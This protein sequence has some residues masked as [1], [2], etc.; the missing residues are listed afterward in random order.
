MDFSRERQKTG[1][2]I[3]THCLELL[4][5]Y[6]NWSLTNWPL[7][8]P[9]IYDSELP[10]MEPRSPAQVIDQAEG[11]FVVDRARFNHL[12]DICRETMI[13]HRLSL[14][15]DPQK[16]GEKWLLKRINKVARK[17]IFDFCEGWLGLS[18]DSNAP[19]STRWYVGIALFNGITRINDGMAENQGYHI[20]EN[21]AL[22]KPPGHWPTK[23]APGPHQ[24]DW[25]PNNK[26]SITIHRNSGGID[27]IHW[28]FDVMEEGDEQRRILL[29]KWMRAMLERPILIEQMSLATRFENIIRSQPEN[30]AVELISSIPRLLEVSK[31]SGLTVLTSIKT[32]T[33]KRVQVALSDILP[34]LLR[35]SFDEGIELI[36]YL[37]CSDELGSRSAAT[38]ALK[39]LAMIDSDEFVLRLAKPANDSNIEIKRL[40]IQSCLRDYLELDPSDS[41]DIFVPLWIENDEVGSVRMREL[42][43]RMQDVDCLS[44]S[45]LVKKI[46]LKAPETMK[47][48]WDIMKIR[49]EER[50]KKWNDYFNGIGDIPETLL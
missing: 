3:H 25:K 38:S 29:I 48:F 22:S 44:F 50:E 34:S 27:A 49:N 42:L 43:L 12:L 30:V 33:E 13:P 40:F 16:E 24:M 21:I 23:P 9:P 15:T 1:A 6:L 11:L 17:I 8:P 18:L 4:N 28:L 7:P 46:N 14:T 31:K 5:E 2:I 20:I 32:R 26:S 35:V 19:D 45:I 36:D 39:E 37:A 47:K 41:Q 10:L